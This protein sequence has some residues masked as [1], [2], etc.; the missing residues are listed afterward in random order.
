LE[1]NI[2]AWQSRVLSIQQT[3]DPLHAAKLITMGQDTTAIVVR[4]AE[5]IEGAYSA[6]PSF[7]PSAVVKTVGSV[8]DI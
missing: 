2:L 1:R 7:C 8:F 5:L 4:A 3:P 6:C